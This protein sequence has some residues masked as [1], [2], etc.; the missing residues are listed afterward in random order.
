MITADIIGQSNLNNSHIERQQTVDV[1][2][3]VVHSG[4]SASEIRF[5]AKLPEYLNDDDDSRAIINKH[6]GDG[7]GI[8]VDSNSSDNILVARMRL[9]AADTLLI[10]PNTALS[11]GIQ[12]KNSN[13]EVMLPELRGRLF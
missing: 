5:V 12:V 1:R 7:G 6:S 11:W 3:R 2:I 4:L 8:V 9:A 10:P 13:G